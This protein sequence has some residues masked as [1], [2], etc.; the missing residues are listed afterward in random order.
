ML[1]NTTLFLVACLRNLHRKNFIM[2]SVHFQAHI[3]HSSSFSSAKV[4]KEDCIL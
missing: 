2:N 3:F 4:L 1:E